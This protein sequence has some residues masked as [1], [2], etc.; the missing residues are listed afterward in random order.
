MLLKYSLNKEK[1]R[2]QDSKVIE[3]NTYRMRQLEPV[4][5]A[6]Q[7]MP[8]A[9][10]KG[11]H[12]SLLSYGDIGYRDSNDVDFLIPRSLDK[13]VMNILRDNG[14][15]EGVYDKNGNYRKLTRQEQI[16]FVNSHQIPPFEKTT[17]NGMLLSV[18]FNTD[19]FWGEYTGNRVDITE[20]LKDV[21]II[22][23]YGIEVKVLSD[24]KCFIQ[25][26]LHHYKEMNAPYYLSEKNAFTEK[27]FQDIYGLYKSRIQKKIDELA[28]FINEYMLEDEFY[29]LLF[30]TG[31]VFQDEDLYQAALQF[32]TSSG[33]K[34]LNQFGLNDYE[35]KTWP[36]PFE[37]RMNHPNIFKVIE[38]LLSSSE[39]DKIKTVFMAL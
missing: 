18:D 2:Y 21:E 39:R 33:I 24:V 26:C 5:K 23:I 31:V 13:E 34:K 4:F 27:M 29:F 22:Q 36:I 35:R 32:Q 16:M 10:I 12:L 7:G 20:Y 1:L 25:T 19:I 6:M 15:V 30:Y 8:Y 28:S 14:F 37:E 11:E 38:P 3:K 17:E 9:L